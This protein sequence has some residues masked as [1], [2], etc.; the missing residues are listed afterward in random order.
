MEHGI[1]RVLGVL[2]E[3]GRGE[4]W[5]R[6]WRMEDTGGVSSVAK[7]ALTKQAAA[8]GKPN[9]R[10]AK[11]CEQRERTLRASVAGLAH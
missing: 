7:T 9:P 6:R 11:L 1:R 5:A 2:H 3:E 8:A 4:S 10:V